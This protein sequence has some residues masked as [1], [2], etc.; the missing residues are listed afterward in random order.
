MIDLK[1]VYQGDDSFFLKNVDLIC[2]KQWYKYMEHEGETIKTDGC[3]V[4]LEALKLIEISGHD[5]SSKLR[6]HIPTWT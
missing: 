2:L 6:R 1:K 3:K 4:L 5:K